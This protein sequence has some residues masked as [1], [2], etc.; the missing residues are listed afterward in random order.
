M[1]GAE[2]IDT[3]TAM[4][5]FDG[6]GRP[7]TTTP[8]PPDENSTLYVAAR[9]R[10]PTADARR[11]SHPRDN[12][13]SNDDNNSSC[14]DDGIA[15][16]PPQRQRLAQTACCECSRFSRCVKGTAQGSSPACACV[17]A[18]RKCTSCA[19][20]NRGCQRKL[21]PITATTGTL[22]SFFARGRALVS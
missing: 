10:P 22:H 12:S 9:G 15:P 3:S 8:P 6:H 14:S 5:I 7:T 11:A 13:P 20:F 16:P 18:S 21:L 17:V 1:E 2:A 19:C 4:V